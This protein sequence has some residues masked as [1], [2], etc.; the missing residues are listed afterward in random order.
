MGYA[1]ATAAREAGADVQL[2]S[3]PVALPAPAGVPVT[4]VE[5]AQELLDA[6]LP[7]ARGCDI[8]IAA[9][10]VADYRPASVAPGKLKRQAGGQ[11]LE[12]APA[13]DILA[14]VA[15]LRPPPFCVGFA[16]ESDDLQV[17]AQKK[18]LKKGIDMIAANLV[19]S[20]LG[21]DVDENALLLVWEGGQLQLEKDTKYRLA[22]RLIEQIAARYGAGAGH[23]IGEN[24]A[25]H[26]AENS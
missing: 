9:A 24:H 10:A 13:A 12:L 26:P 7:M 2:V 3:G 25:K 20:G 23:R 4:R 6:V 14:A 8:F 21:F 5:S 19:G 18:R 16:A 1:V 22:V 11:T 15:A 17:N